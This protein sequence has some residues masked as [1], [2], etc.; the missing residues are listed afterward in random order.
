[1]VSSHRQANKRHRDGVDTPGKQ[2]T[3]TIVTADNIM[4]F[5][6]QEFGSL[7]AVAF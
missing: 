4:A 3:S 2:K 1:M 5:T 6:L 7:L